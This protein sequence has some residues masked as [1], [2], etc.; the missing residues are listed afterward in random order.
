MPI[1]NTKKPALSITTGGGKWIELSIQA[2]PIYQTVLIA[3]EKGFWRAVRSGQPPLLFDCEPPK[4][5][6][7]SHS[8]HERL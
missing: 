1:A 2:D 5:W 7:G 4:P 3:A 8:R 6:I